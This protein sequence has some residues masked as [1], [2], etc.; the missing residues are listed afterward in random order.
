MA[1]PRE[2]LIKCIL[3]LGRV[4]GGGGGIMKLKLNVSSSQDKRSSLRKGCVLWEFEVQVRLIIMDVLPITL[5]ASS[6]EI[7]G[8]ILITEN[9][10]HPCWCISLKKLVV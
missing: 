6:G 7:K 9:K 1:S 5:S 2:K 4:L 3:A 10:L 8:F